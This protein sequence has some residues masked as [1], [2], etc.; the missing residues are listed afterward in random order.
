LESS[1]P[2]VSI[3][4]PSYNHAQWIA[5]AIESVLNQTY[6]NIEL[7]IVDDGS[8]DASRDV[9]A[10]YVDGHKVRAFFKE[11]NAGQGHSIN[12]ALN[13][14]RGDY[15]SILPSDD[16]YLPE[17]TRMQVTLFQSLP[18]I[19]GLV[20]GHGLR[21][22]EKTKETKRVA[23]PA[24]RG[25]VFL[26]LIKNGNFIYPASP[27]FRKSVFAKFRFDE[28]YGAEGESIFI[29][30]ASEY[31]FDYVDSD[32]VVMRAHSYNTGSAHHMM[33]QD[34][35]RWWAEYFAADSTPQRAKQLKNT[36]LSKLH[37]MYGLVLLTECCDLKSARAALT[38]ALVLRPF[39]FFDIKVATAILLT[40]MPKK[41]VL[42]FVKVKRKS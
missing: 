23:L 12:L 33:Y 18:Q 28:T 31:E 1:E 32:V 27:M 37:R 38:K 3:I 11:K 9:I 34:N 20:Y 26:N 17:K 5:Q 41:F 39:K 4:I 19:V 25:G 35:I 30:I 21:Y 6:E 22:F 10:K 36:V 13:M 15:I 40:F 8:K 29:K 42:N 14:C 7:I 24:H 2:L 16:W